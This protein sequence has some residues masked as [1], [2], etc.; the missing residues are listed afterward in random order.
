[1]T[2]ELDRSFETPDG[3]GRYDLFVPDRPEGRRLIVLIHGG[4]WVGG[5]KSDYHDEA[6][7][8]AEKGVAAAC[9]GYRLAPAWPFP[10]AVTDV[11][12]AVAHLRGAGQW[13]EVFVFGNSAG[14]HLALMAAVCDR[15]LG[16]A[17]PSARPDKVVA[18]CPITDL[19]AY[20]GGLIPEAEEFLHAFLGPPTGD[21]SKWA[22]A[23]PVSYVRPG[24][25]PTLLIH[26]AEDW[27]VPLEQSR[28]MA[29]A[30]ADAGSPVRLMELP[31][32]E[33][34]FTWESW[35]KV[36]SAA[37]GHFLGDARP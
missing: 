9:V 27:L 17:R 25:P 10:A 21:P 36:R 1:M 26:G 22:Q 6:R 32:E 14:G 15:I 2:V 37:A 7:F 23:S 18:V 13:D 5:D 3:S 4:G 8:W 20:R 29:R 34:S 30:L 11:Q 16:S 24:L 33:H 35:S 19:R 28:I 31:G 12:C